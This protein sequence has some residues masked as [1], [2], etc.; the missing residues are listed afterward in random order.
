MPP[1]SRRI[2]G[3]GVDLLDTRRIARLLADASP[4]RRDR[5]A[6]RILTPRE[7][8]ELGP[9]DRSVGPNDVAF[10]A[11][12]WAAKEAVY[13]ACYPAATLTWQDVEV[14]KL[15][16]TRKPVV[17]VLRPASLAEALASVHLSVSHDGP[18]LVA[19]VVAEEWVAESEP[20]S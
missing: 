9:T 19:M 12:R 5:F 15:G 2:L 3:I 18:M 11:L 6:R 8:A 20:E 1:A 10:L 16:G 13:K 17:R 4:A 7:R 14:L